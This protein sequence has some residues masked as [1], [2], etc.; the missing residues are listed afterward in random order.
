[1][2]RVSGLRCINKNGV[3]YKKL[4]KEGVIQKSAKSNG[5]Q[6]QA[7]TTKQ[8]SDTDTNK[9]KTKKCASN[10][11]LNPATNRC[12]KKDGAVYKKLL[13]Q[14]EN[15]MHNKKNEN[16]GQQASNLLESFHKAGDYEVYNHLDKFALT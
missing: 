6:T 14:K 10:Q 7:K 16:L 11:I 1:M 5:K 8:K 13:K 4:Y 2:Q 12:I 3:L 15:N 9:D